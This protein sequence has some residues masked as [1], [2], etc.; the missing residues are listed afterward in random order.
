MR[1]VHFHQDIVQRFIGTGSIAIGTAATAGSE[2]QMHG[3]K[4][5]QEL[6]DTINSLRK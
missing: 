2:I 1:G 6:V 3:L 5:A 4:N